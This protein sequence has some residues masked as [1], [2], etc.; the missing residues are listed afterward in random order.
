[1]DELIAAFLD[2]HPDYAP[3]TRR[4]YHARLR[5][6]TRWLGVSRWRDVDE[7]RLDRAIAHI[8]QQG[9]TVQT[10][11]AY[12]TALHT[13]ANW[14]AT[15]HIHLPTDRLPVINSRT[16]S[17]TTLAP[18]QI[19]RLLYLSPT[20]WQATTVRNVAMYALLW[21]T[22]ITARE[23]CAL[24]LGDIA[25]GD[26]ELYVAGRV[27]PIYPGALRLV[28]RYIHHVRPRT[29]DDRQRAMFVAYDGKR[30]AWKK[31]AATLRRFAIRCGVDCTPQAI[32]HTFAMHLHS[33]GVSASDLQAILGHS[34]HD[35]AYRY[36]RE[37][38][39]RR[40]MP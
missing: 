28:R 29:T 25:W 31:C 3:A 37:L 5:N 36:Y 1:M 16:E 11:R 19:A 39:S 9:Y 24:S 40:E 8:A 2:A 32:R 6:W 10:R 15:R 38:H 12:Y 35:A 23:L 13:F 34:S 7:K 4:E 17:V 14:L 30:M 22:G 33:N 27:L 18:Q 20:E 21:A 26:G